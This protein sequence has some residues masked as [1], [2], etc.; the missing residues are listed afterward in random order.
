MTENQLRKDGSKV[1]VGNLSTSR[2]L[3]SSS[4]DEDWPK[5][6]SVMVMNLGHKDSIYEESE[7]ADNNS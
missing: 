6:P 4:K 3:R 7:A 1:T 5:G 2:A